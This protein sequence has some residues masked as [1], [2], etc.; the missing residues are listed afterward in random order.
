MVQVQEPEKPAKSLSLHH[1]AW[2]CS[3]LC[4]DECVREGRASP[5]CSHLSRGQLV[6]SH[7]LF[8]SVFSAVV[9]CSVFFGVSA[10]K[11]RSIKSNCFHF[12]G[13]WDVLS[14]DRRT[15]C[16]ISD[17]WSKRALLT[18]CV[19]M[20]IW[21]PLFLHAAVYHM[22]FLFNDLMSS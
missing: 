15:D 9:L 4:C 17:L 19:E 8:Q 5:F 12:P 18:T 11:L 16:V 6:E 21:I 14:W 7:A 20:Y 22:F 10:S 3:E 2:E 13:C 1:R